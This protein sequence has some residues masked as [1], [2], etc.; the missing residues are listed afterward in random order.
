M[1]GIGSRLRSENLLAGGIGIVGVIGTEDLLVGLNEIVG[2]IG[3]VGMIGIVG[4][5]GTEHLL[6]RGRAMFKNLNDDRGARAGDALD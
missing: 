4:A 5:I 3:I 6:S 1:I 2:V